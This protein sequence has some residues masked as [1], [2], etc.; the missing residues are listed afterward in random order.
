M[1][2]LTSI[3]LQ[4]VSGGLEKMPRPIQVDVRRIIIAVLERI[5]V[6]LG[7]GGMQRFA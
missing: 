7:G 5:I 3:E 6:K 4:A 2:E 1:R